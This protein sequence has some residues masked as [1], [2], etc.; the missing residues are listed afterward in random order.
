MSVSAF[1]LN[2]DTP[3]SMLPNSRRAATNTNTTRT[4]KHTSVHEDILLGKY[5][6]KF[7]S[8]SSYDDSRVDRRRRL[9]LDSPYLQKLT[10]SNFLHTIV[11]GAGNGASGGHHTSYSN[12]VVNT[13]PNSSN[14]TRSN[15]ESSA[16]VVSSSRSAKKDLPYEN[17]QSTV[18]MVR[19][20][21][22]KPTISDSLSQQKDS[23]RASSAPLRRYVIDNVKKNGSG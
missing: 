23:G 7:Q 20:I 22:L 11:V 9:E 12:S 10:H 13:R 21:N 14:R 2:Y 3:G 15:T 18:T 5:L 8:P 4:Y 6:E 16:A 17:S 19:R 1:E